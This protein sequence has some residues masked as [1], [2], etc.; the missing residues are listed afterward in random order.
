MEIKPRE[1]EQLKEEI[2]KRLVPICTRFRHDNF[3]KNE[4]KQIVED[5]YDELENYI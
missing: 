3:N 4:V 1:Q 2:K 5:I